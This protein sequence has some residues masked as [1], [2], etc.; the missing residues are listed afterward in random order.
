MAI[1]Y[2][3]DALTEFF[4]CKP[5]II[6]KEAMI[7]RY[8]TTDHSSYSITFY[9]NTYDEYIAVALHYIPSNV[10]MYDI[11]ISYANTIIIKTNKL[12]ITKHNQTI[13][14]LSKK[15]PHFLIGHSNGL[16]I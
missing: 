3:M 12:L 8:K 1:I 2:D 5:N 11:G 7:L 10:Y 14:A 16:T 4:G 15:N 13:I 6:D 9:I